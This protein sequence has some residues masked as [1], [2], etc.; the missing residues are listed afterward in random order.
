[1]KNSAGVHRAHVR[2]QPSRRR[3]P[4]DQLPP[5]GRGGAATSSPMRAR[6]CCFADDEFAAVAGALDLPVMIVD[7]AAQHDARAL[8]PAEAQPAPRAH[9]GAER[10]VPPD[11]HLGHHRPA[12]GRDA[13][14]RQF[15]LEVLRP[16]RRARARP[17]DDRLLVVGP[18]YHVGAFDLPGMAVLLGRRH[19]R[20]APRLRSGRGA[21]ARS[22]ASGSPAP[23][24]RRSC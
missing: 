3:V 23:G 10:S 14:L 7:G 20:P 17:R 4:A 11:V 19:A 22:R 1:M 21:V 18:L 9:C 12:Q 5:R 16:H 13:H 8:F 24:S 6:S 15:L 2:G